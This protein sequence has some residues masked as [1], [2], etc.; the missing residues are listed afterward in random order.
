L[1]HEATEITFRDAENNI[2]LS[3]VIESITIK[4]KG[5]P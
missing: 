5:C 4:M 2:F 1:K 3:A